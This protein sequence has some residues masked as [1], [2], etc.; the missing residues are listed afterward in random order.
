MDE[1]QGFDGMFFSVPSLNF[2]KALCEIIDNSLD[3]SISGDV[4]NKLHSSGYFWK[5]VT[6]RRKKIN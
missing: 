5:K 3:K 6:N 1:L 2:E 4:I